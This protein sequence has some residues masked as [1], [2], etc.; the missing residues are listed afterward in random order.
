MM[1]LNRAIIG[2]FPRLDSGYALKLIE[3]VVE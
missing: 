1:R 2:I 3:V